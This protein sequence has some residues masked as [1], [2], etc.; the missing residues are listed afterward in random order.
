L[1]AF[2]LLTDNGSTFT[3]RLTSQEKRPTGEHFFDLECVKFCTAHRLCLPQHLQTNGM[4]ERFHWRISELTR[5][6]GFASAAELA[7]TLDRHLIFYNPLIPQR[8]LKHQTPIHALQKWQNAKPELFVK[9][10]YNQP[11]LDTDA[12]L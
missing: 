9:P 4:V 8:A 1:G 10:V 7:T 6:T 11:G 5:Q 2:K 12:R 3:D